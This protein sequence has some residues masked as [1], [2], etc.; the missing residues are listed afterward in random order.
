M[1]IINRTPDSFHDAGATYALDA[2]L[3]AADQALS[4][5]ADIIDIGGVKAGRGEP[6]TVSEEIDR[7]VPV[8]QALSAAHPEAV[9]SVDTWRSET[10]AAAARA[11]A[12]PDQR[13]LGGPRPPGRGRGG[14]GRDWAG[15]YPRRAPGPPDGPRPLRLRG[16]SW[17]T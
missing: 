7:V 4:Q 6:V 17:P 14:P 15:L 13:L 3:G 2:A 8:I 16:T 11:G 1:A 10:A 9:I 12:G 5:G